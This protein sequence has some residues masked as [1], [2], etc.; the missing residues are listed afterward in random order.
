MAPELLF[1]CAPTLGG[2]GVPP[3]PTT[4]SN[5]GGSAT[6]PPTQAAAAGLQKTGAPLGP[7]SASAAPTRN[8]GGWQP[9]PTA[10]VGWRDSR[11]S[12]GARPGLLRVDACCA[13]G[14]VL[15]VLQLVDQVV[16]Q[17]PI[18]MR[19]PLYASVALSGGTSG[20]RNFA[21]RVHVRGRRGRAGRATGCCGCE[22]GR[23]L[24]E[25]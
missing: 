21:R 22:R 11:I 8:V 20:I 15:C 12:L 4:T 13:V 24:P 6:P 5:A 18:D 16:Q 3:P 2:G 10:S 25:C 19:R 1:T 23:D 17:C 9:L 7:P 14:R